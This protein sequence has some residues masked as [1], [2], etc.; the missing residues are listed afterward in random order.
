MA[1]SPKDRARSRPRERNDFLSMAALCVAM[2]FAAMTG[3]CSSPSQSDVG[4]AGRDVAYQPKNIDEM[5]RAKF[6]EQACHD[7]DGCPF[8]THCN[9]AG[10]CDYECVSDDACGEGKSCSDRGVCGASLSQFLGVATT[11]PSCASKSH[12]EIVAALEALFLL[13]EPDRPKCQNDSICPCGSF[14]NTL[15]GF[16]DV[17]CAP[18]NDSTSG[19]LVCFDPTPTC[20][21]L[22]R[23]VAATNPGPSHQLIL[24]MSPD[25]ATGNPFSAPVLVPITVS[26]QAVSSDVVVS[27]HPAPVRYHF[28]G[29]DDPQF[30]SDAGVNPGTVPKVKC[31]QTDP[32]ATSCTIDGGWTFPADNLSSD[33]KTIWVQ[34][35]QTTTAQTWTLQ[36]TSEWAADLDAVTVKSEPVAPSPPIPGHYHGL[37]RLT[38]NGVPI[39]A[40]VDVLVNDDYL[41]V[42]DQSKS[43]L[44]NGHALL[45][46]ASNK[47]TLLGWLSASTAAGAAHYDVRVQL[48]APVQDTT[49]GHLE[50][51][52]STMTIGETPAADL[53]LSLDRDGDLGAKACA[54]PS[55]CPSNDPN[56]PENDNYCDTTFGRCLPGSGPAVESFKVTGQGLDNPS[57][58]L[59]STKVSDWAPSVATMASGH[60]G[61]LKPGVVGVEA[62]YCA[63]N[64]VDTN[65]NSLPPRFLISSRIAGLPG[66]DAELDGASLDR[67]C[68]PPS[69]ADHL[70]QTFRFAD[71]TQEVIKDAQN[72]ADVALGDTCTTEIGATPTATLSTTNCVSLG[73]FFLALAANVANGVGQPGGHV[74][75]RL[76]WQ[77]LRQWLGVNSYIASTNVRLEPYHDVVD[78]TS[79]PKAATFA[80]A[81]DLMEVNLKVLLDPTVRPQFAEGDALA[82]V[83]A[84]PDYRPLPWPVVYWP[85]SGVFTM[86]ADT[87]LVPD[88]AQDN[89]V[90][91]DLTDLALSTNIPLTQVSEELVSNGTGGTRSA[92][93]TQ[94]VALDDQSF[95]IVAALNFVPFNGQ[96]Q[97]LL[98]KT[99]N[100]DLQLT[101]ATADWGTHVTFTLKNPGGGAAKFVVPWYPTNYSSI[102]YIGLVADGGRYTMYVAS[103]G[104][105]VQAFA[106]TSVTSGGPRW[107]NPGPVSLQVMMPNSA[108]CTGLDLF[109]PG[110]KLATWPGPEFTDWSAFVWDWNTTTNT[111]EGYGPES[112]FTCTSH[113][114]HDGLRATW[115][116]QL[117][118]SGYPLAARNEMD[119]TA[120]GA[121]RENAAE[122]QYTD[123]SHNHHIVDQYSC[124]LRIHG[125]PGAS[126]WWKPACG[127]DAP[128]AGIWNRWDDVSLWDSPI[129]RAQFTAMASEYNFTAMNWTLR[130]PR[131]TFDPT[132][133]QAVGLPVYLVEAANAHLD[134]LN[135]YLTVEDDN[136]YA[137]CYAGRPSTELPVARD[138]AGR[139]LRLAL[140]LQREAARL[141]AFGGSSPTWKPRYQA[142][143]QQFAARVAD[144]QKHLGFLITCNNSL[145]IRDDQ[146]PL[147][148]GTGKDTS[149]SSRFFATSD[150]LVSLATS[151]STVAKGLLDA[152]R[153]AYVNQ[154]L[155]SFQTN[156]GAGSNEKTDRVNALNVTYED[157]LKAYC[158]PAPGDAAGGHPLLSGFSSGAIT[159]GSCYLKLEDTE[160]CHLDKQGN[161]LSDKT[162]VEDIPDACVRGKLGELVVTMHSAAIDAAN[163]LNAIDRATRE[164]DVQTTYCNKLSQSLDA[165]VG[166]LAAHNDTMNSLS[167][168]RAAAAAMSALCN[169][170]M[171]IATS[172]VTTGGV[173]AAFQVAATA[174]T[175]G[176]LLGASE[177][178]LD[179]EMAH[180]NNDYQLEVAKRSAEQQV[181]ACMHTADEQHFA[182]DA[183][184]DASKRAAEES[185]AAALAFSNA[186]DAVR[187][188]AAEGASQ[189]ALEDTINRTPPQF[190]YWFDASVAEYQ[191]HFAFAQRLSFLAVRAYEYENMSDTGKRADVL[192]AR[193]PADLDTVNTYILNHTAPLAGGLDPKPFSAVFSLRDEIMKLG[194]AGGKSPTQ[195]LQDILKSNPIFNDDQ[196]GHRRLFG[197]GIPFVIADGESWNDVLC[198]ERIWRLTPIPVVTGGRPSDSTVVLFQTNSFG[199]Q[200]CTKEHPIKVT[201][202]HQNGNLLDDDDANV[203]FE[204]PDSMFATPIVNFPTDDPTTLRSLS[205]TDGRLDAS[206]A[207]RGI[208]GQ[209]MLVFPLCDPTK[210]CTAG[211][212]QAK[213]DVLTDVLFRLDVASASNKAALPKP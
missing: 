204:A 170:A 123:A 128:G 161:V 35:P 176:G 86:G 58:T 74:R 137:D 50:F 159:A 135:R 162:K 65:P 212:T 183:A 67:E 8:G 40:L 192:R 181:A 171:S 83:V 172:A 75:Q 99:G 47:V 149:G 98:A 182:I 152:A 56:H 70:Q 209:Y 145:N 92:V 14:C 79:P 94:P 187:A 2:G 210:G 60:P 126:F 61:T 140:V 130:G 84:H 206:M 147:Y 28:V 68:T 168:A 15:S 158:G 41:A 97:V 87:N 143:L 127:P 211:F 177:A 169:S 150:F 109:A 122:Q 95:S 55:N 46:R 77:I 196:T 72:G 7:D 167:D 37:L 100:P 178:E 96:E 157:Q 42:T 163:A 81:L 193:I 179:N 134:L 151:Q 184:C 57:V 173:G 38:S 62:A 154:R 69:G 32:L 17:E 121:I 115:D 51:P 90:L 194:P 208:F 144:V 20:N 85:F 30:P 11:D 3:A 1:T 45:A 175:V 156:R 21:P 52:S 200:I 155:S 34:L 190:H 48:G 166:E 118:L 73:R 139:S 25:P 5:Q 36:A 102:A 164:Y 44:P 199:S 146:I 93:T 213:L 76:I 188:A 10:K 195:R 186:V 49:T 117:A 201:R 19:N 39:D 124:E 189:L 24:Q 59:A 142:A 27:P 141:A 174:G 54:T 132:N 207:G 66:T 105:A 116:G 43:L 119:F 180:E 148:V 26:V 131:G 165:G 202:I 108:L 107:G 82:D 29:I 6:H 103:A 125:W 111:T 12:D 197:Y 9:D 88:V 203:N 80:T 13:D 71:R 22:G 104:Q 23:C 153:T 120:T 129:T 4:R 185:V 191:R 106:P 64:A 110:D 16:C 31:A 78:G 133:E 33:T 91:E 53:T 198:D 63:E 160:K 113:K 89:T 205:D 138:R 18:N 114:L 101:E 112:T 136:V